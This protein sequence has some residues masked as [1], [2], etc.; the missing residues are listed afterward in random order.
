MQTFTREKIVVGTTIRAKKNKNPKSRTKWGSSLAQAPLSPFPLSSRSALLHV[1]VLFFALLFPHRIVAVL[2]ALLL[3]SLR[4][5]SSLV[6]F[7]SYKVLH[8]II[9]LF[10]LLCSPHCAIVV[11]VFLFV[12]ESCIILL[13]SFLQELGVVRS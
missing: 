12:E 1:V 5:Y 10:A 9:L 2:F 4:S 3:F 6:V 8:A 11:G 13:H 7:F